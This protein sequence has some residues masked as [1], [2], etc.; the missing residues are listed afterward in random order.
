MLVFFFFCLAARWETNRPLGLAEGE[1]GTAAAEHCGTTL[2]ELAEGGAQS[3]RVPGGAAAPGAAPG[4]LSS[5]VTWTHE[6]WVL[7]CYLGALIDICFT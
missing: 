7:G 4:V 3:Q 1:L 5:W 6:T 2:K